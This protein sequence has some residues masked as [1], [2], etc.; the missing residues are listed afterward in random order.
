MFFQSIVIGGVLVL[1]PRKN[2]VGGDETNAL[3]MAIE[4]AAA[5]GTARVVL[6]LGEISW[7]NSLGIGS[8][9]RASMSCTGSGGWLRLARVGQITEKTLRVTGLLIYFD[10]FETVD[11]AL[12]AP[13]RA[14][15]LP[16]SLSRDA[17]PRTPGSSSPR[18]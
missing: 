8:L 7:V 4:E 14:R 5:Q 15:P 17:T 12:A 3:L 16:R 13:D 10:T 9:K 6:D 2:L 18:E 11:Q 1:T